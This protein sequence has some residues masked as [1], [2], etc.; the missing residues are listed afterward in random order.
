MDAGTQHV[1][2]LPRCLAATGVLLLF[3]VWSGC[4]ARTQ[5]QARARAAFEAGQR[6]ALT[7]VANRQ[8]GITFIGPVLNPVI[9]W[10]QGLTLGQAVAAAGWNEQKSPR[11]IV[12]TRNGES[13]EMTPAQML[14]AAEFPVEP[15][16]RVEMLP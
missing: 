16:D 1:R 11:L 9:P 15:G 7:D 8:N 10:R 12:L 2:A 6:Q 13:V 4:S 14:Q 3:I 5:S